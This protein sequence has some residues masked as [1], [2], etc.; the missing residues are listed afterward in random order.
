[1]ENGSFHFYPDKFILRVR[2]RICNNTEELLKSEPF[3]AFFQHF[4]NTLKRQQSKLLSIFPE[5]QFDE[6]KTQ[7][8]LDTLFYLNSLPG[9]MVVKLV[10]G[11]AIFFKDIQL[12]NEFVE[13]LY[14]Y[15]RRLHR[16]VI[17]DSVFDRLDKKP[18]RTFNDTVES[19]MHLVRSSYRNIQE[20]I[21]GIHPKIYR[22]VSAGAEIGAIALP[23]KMKYPNSDYEILDD[24][25]VIRQVLIYP[26]MIFNTPNNK[27][28]GKFARIE[29][30]PLTGLK[31]NPKEWLG[32]PAKVGPLLIMIYFPL[33]YFEL[34]FSLSN[35]FEL[36]DENDLK[37]KPDAVYLYGTPPEFKVG[38]DGNE[39]VFFDDEDHKM[40]VA[41]VPMEDE[42]AYFGYLKKMILTLHNIIQ[43]KEGFLPFHGAMIQLTMRNKAPYTVVILGD[44][45]AGKSESI[46]ALRL[47]AGDDIEDML[48]I[49]DDMG[50]IGIDKKGRLVGY[51]TEMGAFVRLDD[52]QSGY[53]LG[54]I[55][56]T[57]IMNP[58]KVNARV[59]MPVT[60]YEYI[61]EGTP[62][63]CVLY[64]N[65]YEVLDNEHPV[66]DR[67]KSSNAALD[68][69]RK[70]SVMSKGTTATHGLVEN[71]FANIFGPPQYRDLHE[72]LAEKYFVEMFSRDVFVGQ[73]RTQ[74][75]IQGEEQSG[76]KTAAKALL[77][78]INTFAKN[79]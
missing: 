75:G 15:W 53:A 13:Q 43:M 70:G 60:R 41:T 35:L 18:Y 77:E 1:M 55:D 67:F 6:A 50:S 4:L 12:F 30:N 42:Y 62:I 76:P 8:M 19:L 7:L 46:E 73:I 64:A 57:I 29:K 20:N 40:M 72:E 52:L 68:V 74:L 28:K 21:T 71:Y 47:M 48:I 39:T 27:R 59:V 32:Y 63:D 65:N 51:G 24:I 79:I 61:M 54:Q 16:L 9:D 56:R 25:F 38:V 37:K 78:M 2:G 10:D 44:S 14:N 31:L 34:G 26:P 36:A 3:K 22:Q 23:K 69:F 66:I 49:A 33:N 17:C 5:K 45:G 11:S 58:D